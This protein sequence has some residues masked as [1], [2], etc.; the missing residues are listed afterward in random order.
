MDSQHTHEE[1]S[2]LGDS[3]PARKWI[4]ILVPMAGAVIVA[5]IFYGAWIVLQRP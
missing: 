3:G 4:P 1:P 2:R 5:V